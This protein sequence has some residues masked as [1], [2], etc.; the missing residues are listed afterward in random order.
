[1]IWKDFFFPKEDRNGQKPSGKCKPKPQ[2]DITSHPLEC[3]L[4]KRQAKTNVDEDVEKRELYCTGLQIGASAVETV[5]RFLKKLKIEI[6]Y[7][8]AILLLCMC[9]KEIKSLSWRGKKKSGN[10]LKKILFIFRERAR[11]EERE[12][13]KHRWEGET[14]ISCLSYTHSEQG[15]NPQPRHVPWMESN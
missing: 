1:M 7:E 6:P 10:V 14:L 12:G 5:W 11:E 3:L 15:L 9:L 2:W 8:A 4:S 13:D